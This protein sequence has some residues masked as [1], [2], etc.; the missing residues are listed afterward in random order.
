MYHILITKTEN[1]F[2]EHL[3]FCPECCTV[4]RETSLNDLNVS[5]SVHFLLTPTPSGK[6]AA[7]SPPANILMGSM[8]TCASE[9]F[10]SYATVD[11]RKLV[12]H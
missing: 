2:L 5:L 9:F 11:N 10:Y 8:V 6:L 3:F 12:L 4:I 7:S 1:I